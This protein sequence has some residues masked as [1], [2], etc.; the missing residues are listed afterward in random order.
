MKFNESLSS[1]SEVVPCG[2]TNTQTDGRTDRLT[3]RHN[4]ANC[5]FSQ[6]FE[7]PCN[8]LA[9]SSNRKHFETCE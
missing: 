4:E 2:K 8:F 7:S 6:F 1:G 3:D 9:M 5:R